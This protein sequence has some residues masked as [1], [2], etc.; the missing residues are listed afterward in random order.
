V[1]SPANLT[2]EDLNPD[3]LT[4]VSFEV[5]LARLEAIVHQLEAGDASLEQSIDIYTEGQRLKAHCEAKLAGASAR[6]ERIQLGA[7]GKPT[8]T[9]PFEPINRAADPG[10]RAASGS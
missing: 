5:A 7:D 3:D 1:S 6:I 10:N 9:V 4:N 8:G 2:P